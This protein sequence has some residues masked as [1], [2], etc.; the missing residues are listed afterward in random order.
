MKSYR[1]F[2]RKKRYSYWK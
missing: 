1:S 2:R